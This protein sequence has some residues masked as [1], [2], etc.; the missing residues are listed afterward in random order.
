MESCAFI[1]KL[2]DFSKIN[3]T[4]NTYVNWKIILL[5]EET[6][7]LLFAGAAAATE[8]SRRTL[9]AGTS[10]EHGVGVAAAGGGSAKGRRPRGAALDVLRVALLHAIGDI[11]AREANARGAEEREHHL[12]RKGDVGDGVPGTGDDLDREQEE[13]EEDVLLEQRD[14]EDD[15]DHEEVEGRGPSS[16][17]QPHL[18]ALRL[19]AREKARRAQRCIGEKIYNEYEFNMKRNHRSLTDDVSDDVEDGE[20]ADVG[21]V[22]AAEEHQ[23][24][25]EREEKAHRLTGDI[26]DDSIIEKSTQN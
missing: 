12:A 1:L 23:R 8:Q 13:H 10:A 9:F 25:H 18:L 16:G 21:R 19:G 7:R 15:D 4:H 24:A 20:D 6:A 5:T 17:G 3:Y 26:S 2:L 11:E 22:G 14:D